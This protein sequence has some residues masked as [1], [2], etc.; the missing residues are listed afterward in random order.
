MN[1]RA[2]PPTLSYAARGL[3]LT[4]SERA[5]Q[6]LAMLKDAYRELNSKKLFWITMILSAVVVG[7]F[8]AVGFD[9]QGFSILWKSFRSPFLNTT[10]LPKAQLYKNLFVSLG[11]Q[12]WLG[13]FAI[14][15]AL[16]STAPMFP[17][18]LSGGAVDLYLARPLGRVRLFLTKYIVGLLFVGIQVAV[19]CLA[20]FLVIGIRG[21]AWV[22]GIFLAVPV[23]VLM[24]SYLWCVCAFVGTITRS[25]IASLLLTMLAWVAVFGV[26]TTEALLLTFSVGSRVEMQEL[27]RDVARFEGEIAS[28]QARPAT[29]KPKSIESVRLKTLEASLQKTRDE[30]AKAD[31]PF[32]T[33]H[34]IAYIAKWPLPKTSETTALLERWLD[35]TFRGPRDR[36]EPDEDES[37][38]RSFFQS[39]RVQRLTAL[40]VDKEIRSRSAAWVIG[41]SLMFEAAVLALTTWF[42]S[43]RDY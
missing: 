12:S 7:A 23:V 43:R 36:P 18:F 26:H 35:R 6:T 14:I 20:S 27:D 30:R 21:G 31:D 37:K 24:F 19:F 25:T 9:E 15:L 38:S 2:E 5:T 29:T 22:P 40:E 34:T 4:F 32:A 33:W 11:V 3:G 17:D 39:P 41:T 16:V 8:G 13:F 42:F 1:T 28:L 10:V